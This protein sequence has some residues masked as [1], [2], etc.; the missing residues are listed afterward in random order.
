MG[1]N[2]SS[3]ENKY[4]GMMA[5]VSADKVLMLIYLFGKYMYM[6]VHVCKCIITNS[7]NN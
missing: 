2:Y 4:N 3:Q 5:V 1:G 6:H 7:I